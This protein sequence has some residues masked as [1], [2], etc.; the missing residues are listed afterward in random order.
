MQRGKIHKGEYGYIPYQRKVTVLWTVF[1]FAVSLSLFAI[2]IWSTG[3]KKNILTMVAVLGCLPASKSAVNM[4]LFLRV[5]GC[6]S[7][8]WERVKTRSKDLP[9]LWDMVFT[10]YDKIYQISHMAVKGKVALGLT[11][12][13]HCSAE[14]CEKH[15][16]IYLKQGGCK[17]VTIKIYQDV[18]KYCQALESLTG[19]ADDGEQLEE[20]L[21]NLIAITL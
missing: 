16:D 13:E 6:S 10:S 12:D 17:G 21:E 9:V 5:K 4:I 14:G 19:Q 7:V 2:G 3:D 20:I 18:E 8:V 11:E 15:L 1:L